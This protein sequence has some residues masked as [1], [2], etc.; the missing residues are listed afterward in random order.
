E[1]QIQTNQ[2]KAG[3][4]QRRDDWRLQKVSAEQDSLVAAAQVTTATDQVTI[5]VQEQ[6]VASLQYDQ[7]VATLKF[8]ND[9]FTNADLYLWMSNTLGGV[10]RY[11][12]QQATAIARLAQAQLAFERAEQPQALLRTGYWQSPAELMSNAGQPDRR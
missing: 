6:S 2:L 3:I 9:Q 4:E 5:A 12:L 7:A 11:F 10:Y 1:A 8:L